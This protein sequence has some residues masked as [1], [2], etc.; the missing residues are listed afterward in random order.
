MVL[1]LLALNLH[2]VCQ[3]FPLS[4]SRIFYLTEHQTLTQSIGPLKVVILIHG[5]QVIEEEGC[6]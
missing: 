5:F 6:E 2:F 3:S 1:D 4:Q